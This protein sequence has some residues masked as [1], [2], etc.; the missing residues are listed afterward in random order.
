MPSSA[1]I[2]LERKSFASSLCLLEA[3]GSGSL[4]E[5]RCDGVQNKCIAA[6]T[7]LKHDAA[8]KP[9]GDVVSLHPR[10]SN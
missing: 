7:I 5:K 8:C 2:L 9:Y 6:G 4:W 10:S 1:T 3:H